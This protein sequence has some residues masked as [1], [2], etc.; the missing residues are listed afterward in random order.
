MGALWFVTGGARSGKS[1]FATQLATATARP[2]VYIATMQPLDEELRARVR[3]HRA[4]RPQSWTTVEAPDDPAAAI[5]AVDPAACIVL[6]C[7]SLWVSNRLLAAGETPSQRDVEALERALER[8]SDAIVA[9]SRQRD[10]ELIV[11]TNEVGSSVVPDN[12]L[13]R[14]YRDLLGRVN[15]RV[16]AESAR[17]WL[18]VSGRPLELPPAER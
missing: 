18:L 14:A 7:L 11:V 13:A 17:A 9:A 15:Q 6:D 3:R 10:G 4:E 2:V 16:A 12:A 5:A 8:E 1:R